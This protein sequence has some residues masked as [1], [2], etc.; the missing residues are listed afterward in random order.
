LGQ[1]PLVQSICEGGDDGKPV[2]MNPFTVEGK[3]F[4]NLAEKVLEEVERRNS[5]LPPTHKVE[6]THK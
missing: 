3:A 2:A 6:I 5:N 1:I 4:A